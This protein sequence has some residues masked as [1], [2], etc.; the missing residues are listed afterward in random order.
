MP[1]TAA[2][3]ARLQKYI[4]ELHIPPEQQDRI[5]TIAEMPR[6]SNSFDDAKAEVENAWGCLDGTE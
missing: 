5:R 2:E 6:Y 1:L 3:E 4:E